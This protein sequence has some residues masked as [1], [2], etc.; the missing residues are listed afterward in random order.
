MNA[1]A[2]QI[3]FSVLSL[4]VLFVA[5][6]IPLSLISLGAKSKNIGSLRRL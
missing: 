6:E 4:L 2:Q 1:N 5:G 3:K